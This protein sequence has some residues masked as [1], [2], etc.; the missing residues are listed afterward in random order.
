M[1]FTI[2]VEV[3]R[4]Q[5]KFASRDEIAEALAEAVEQADLS[6]LGADGT[7]EYVINDVSVS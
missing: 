2:E 6:S 3:E 4:E 5:G 1:H 7:S